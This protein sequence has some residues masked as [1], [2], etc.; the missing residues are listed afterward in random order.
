MA[1]SDDNRVALLL[2][3][4]VVIVAVVG[5]VFMFTGSSSGVV[6]SDGDDTALTGEAFKIAQ[7]R[8]QARTPSVRTAVPSAAVQRTAQVQVSP[9]VAIQQAQVITPQVEAYWLAKGYT[10]S[11]IVPAEFTEEGNLLRGGFFNGMLIGDPGEIPGGMSEQDFTNSIHA[12][13]PE[14]EYVCNQLPDSD[15]NCP[16]G[17]YKL[18]GIC[19]CKTKDIQQIG[20]FINDIAIFVEINAD[21]LS[22]VDLFYLNQLQIDALNDV[23][24]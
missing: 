11:D 10:A 1:K 12:C 18:N 9:N 7:A 19:K 17:C 2:F 22:S 5:L 14:P 21:Y 24:E 6:V 13:P 23:Y 3:G 4:V 16:A 15:G 8:T 20:D